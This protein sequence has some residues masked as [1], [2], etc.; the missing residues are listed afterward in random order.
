MHGLQ[1]TTEHVLANADTPVRELLT[2]M[3]GQ[4]TLRSLHANMAD[5]TDR[6]ENMKHDVVQGKNTLKLRIV[7]WLLLACTLALC[8]R[9]YSMAGFAGVLAA[10]AVW[11][12]ALWL[13]LP[14]LGGKDWKSLRTPKRKARKVRGQWT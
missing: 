2:T 10:F 5:M 1:K 9:P 13:W 4:G 14:W 3:A 7:C 6:L 11:T 12:W 8:E